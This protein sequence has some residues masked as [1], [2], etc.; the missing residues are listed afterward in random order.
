MLIQQKENGNKGKFFI[1]K[2]GE[3]LAEMTYTL[4]AP[5]IM[6]IDHTEVSDDLRGKK[7][8]YQLVQRGADYAREKH[9]KIIPLCLFASAL[10][11]KKP[12]EFADVL[13]T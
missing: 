9:F 11:K 8:G 3:E 7:I 10:F 12:A 13:K 2:D 5:D 6:T 4:A 1:E